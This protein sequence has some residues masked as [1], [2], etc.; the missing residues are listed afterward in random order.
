MPVAWFLL[1][2]KESSSYKAVLQFLKE[3]HNIPAMEV[4]HLDFELAESKAMKEVYPSNQVVGCDFHWKQALQKKFK[5]N[6]LL[7]VYNNDVD[8]QVWY[9]K[10]WSLSMVPHEDIIKTFEKIRDSV[11][12]YEEEDDDDGTGAQL[13]RRFQDYLHYLEKTWI[14]LPTNKTRAA[15]EEKKR[16]K[17]R[18]SWDSWNHRADLLEGKE[19]TSNQSESYNSSSKVNSSTFIIFSVTS[20]SST[21]IISSVTSLLSGKSSFKV[22]HLVCPGVLVL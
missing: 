8:V 4:A 19:V 22:Q 11:P 9:R 5:K 14:G 1:P 13:N 7:E 15:T 6:H 20:L 18:F 2:N 21:F 17:P 10:I 16:K 12:L 3:E